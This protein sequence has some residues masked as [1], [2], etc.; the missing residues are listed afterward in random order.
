MNSWTVTVTVP[1][2]A[3]APAVT[4]GVG[5]RYPSLASRQL[6]S[7]A[8]PENNMV[9]P[10]EDVKKPLVE[11]ANQDVDLRQLPGS[12]SRKRSSTEIGEQ[13]LPKKTKAEVFD[14]LFRN[15]DVDLQ[16]LPPNAPVVMENVP[17]SQPPPPVISQSS[18]IPTSASSQDSS[19]NPTSSLKQP[20]P[21][22]ESEESE[23]CMDECKSISED[24]GKENIERELKSRG[25]AKYKEKKPDTCKSALGPMGCSGRDELDLQKS[26]SSA[27]GSS[28]QLRERDMIYGNP[29]DRGLSNFHRSSGK[30]DKLG[31]PLLYHKLPDDTGERRR[32]LSTAVEEDMNHH[33]FDDASDIS[34][35]MIMQEV[36]EQLKNGTI[37][38]S[39]YNTVLK[40][41]IQL[42]E[43]QKLRDAQRR[44][45][46]ESKENWEPSRRRHAWE[47]SH[48]SPIIADDD[49]QGGSSIDAR[50]GDIDERLPVPH[51]HK[52]L[53]PSLSSSSELSMPGRFQPGPSQWND[54]GRPHMRSN[55]R[56]NGRS[57]NRFRGPAPSLLKQQQARGND[58]VPPADPMILKLIAQDRMRTI[59]VDGVPRE[60]RFYGD[61][62]V[63]ML[64][65]D[66]PREIGFQGGAR[67]VTFDER[68]SIL[69]SLNDTYREFII[70]G[71]MHRIRL[72]AP[73][74]EL[75]VDGKWYECFFGGPPVT[76]EIDGKMHV[77][78]LEGPPPKVKIGLLKRTDLVAGKINLIINAKT[79][80]P[81]FLDAKPQRFDIENK[82]HV[83]HFVK[84]LSTVL[85]NGQPIKVEFGGVP[86]PII[87]HGK[88]HFIR[89]TMLPRGI[90]PGYVS[91]V[92]MEG[93]RLPSPPRPKIEN[94][95]TLTF[96][97]EDFR[98]P[99]SRFSEGYEPVLPVVGATG[100]LGR[101]GLR[102]Q[103][104]ANRDRDLPH[105][106]EHAT[107][108]PG[109][110]HGDNAVKGP[111]PI[112][113]QKHRP[114][115]AGAQLHGAGLSNIP[116]L[117]A[118]INVAE[119]FQRLVAAGIVPQ[120][121][122]SDADSK[123]EEEAKSI[124]AVDFGQPETLKLR[125]PGAVAI[126]FSGIQCSSCGIRFP[127]GQTVK[128]R[129]HLD[130]HFWQNRRDKDNAHKAQSRE[131]YY[132]ASDWIR[133]EEIE[134][135]EERAQS[136]FETQQAVEAEEKEI[137]KVPSVCA[138][139]NPEDAF[140]AVC[141]DKFEQFFHDDEEEWHLR[142]ALRVDGKT[143]HPL[144]YDDYKVSIFII[145][146]H[147]LLKTLFYC[148]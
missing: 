68:E 7:N 112:Q 97:R 117:P 60:L 38:F 115:V 138:G 148:L 101:R 145:M 132:D 104:G 44:D 9:Q 78:R 34:V 124:K 102:K 76:I 53:T 116:S 85:I 13:P 37:S 5:S 131:W 109:Q 121:G 63:V 147:L 107:N 65:W 142:S 1:E 61:T 71:S 10:H 83:L 59:N 56:F 81:V 48:L 100:S 72:G 103:F 66:D 93:S 133:F 114:R 125:Q 137:Q 6:Q 89:F 88:K 75:Y 67:T 57:D 143:Y 129:K 77:V 134:D 35:N 80:V 58:E 86:K 2:A 140:C 32:S 99:S 31:Q 54:A 79:M 17:P 96:G 55:T 128:Y 50:F 28:S 27:L 91:I 46:Q 3:G 20:S 39:H 84:A 62:A 29:R 73:T 108:S 123:E 19:A 42:N 21:E 139:E 95:G 130:W 105:E 69:C 106:T 87:V 113:Q 126:L 41:V 70:D 23:V 14:E 146:L 111:V 127:P 18:P 4:P 122:K 45:Q 16:Q 141:H 94:N 90:R 98:H 135:T 110:F 92:N 52:N 74:R 25:W 118:E 26:R 51:K 40:Q 11:A 43:V 22:R 30:F 119:L 36:E 24:D 15:E 64:A 12:P 136:W 144:C 33:L 47:T 49:R 82:P 8:V 120:A